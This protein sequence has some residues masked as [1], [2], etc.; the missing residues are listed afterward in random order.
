MYYILSRDDEY[1]IV[2][3][4]EGSDPLYGYGS[5]NLYTPQPFITYD[6]AYNYLNN[7]VEI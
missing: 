1:Q 5:W 4:S 2:V 3:S 7:L 6:E